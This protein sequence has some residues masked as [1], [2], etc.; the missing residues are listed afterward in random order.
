MGLVVTVTSAPFLMANPC[1]GTA[2]CFPSGLP[3]YREVH[4]LAFVLACCSHRQPVPRH[5]QLLQLPEQGAFQPWQSTACRFQPFCAAGWRQCRCLPCSVQWRP[6]GPAVTLQTRQAPPHLLMHWPPVLAEG[7]GPPNH[8]L[9]P[10]CVHQHC[11]QAPRPL[12]R[13]LQVPQ[14][15]L[16]VLH[17]APLQGSPSRVSARV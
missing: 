5:T 9:P 3:S 10:E 8:E 12:H 13:L 6:Q 1:R 15:L 16:V 4:R 2:P 17:R 11:A 7:V 14:R